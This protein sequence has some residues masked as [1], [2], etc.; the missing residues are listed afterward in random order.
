[1]NLKTVKL[2]IWAACIVIPMVPTVVVML[3][4]SPMLSILGDIVVSLVEYFGFQYIVALFIKRIAERR[5]EKEKKMKE[6]AA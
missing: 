6:S 4:I 1:M 5:Q 2:L 3:V